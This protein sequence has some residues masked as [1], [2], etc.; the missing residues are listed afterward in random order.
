M[1]LDDV[2]LHARQVAEGCA[3]DNRD[4]AYQHD[5]LADWLD[6][7]KAYRALGTIDH[8]RELV[9]RDAA[10]MCK[11]QTINRGMDA[12]GEYDIDY[13]LICPSCGAVVGDAEYNELNGPF[14]HK[15]GKRLALPCEEAEAEGPR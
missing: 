3:S 8:L 4:C 2:I 7:L 5:R 13:N 12:T 14:C 10:Q 11:A 15:C 1:E 9:Q 6:K